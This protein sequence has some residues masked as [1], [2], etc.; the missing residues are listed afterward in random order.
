MALP[1]LAVALSESDRKQQNGVP[2]KAGMTMSFLDPKRLC[3]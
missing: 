1:L 2:S 3:V